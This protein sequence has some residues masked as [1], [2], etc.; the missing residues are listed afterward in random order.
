MA[1]KLSKANGAGHD[2]PKPKKERKKREPV[3]MPAVTEEQKR[4]AMDRLYSAAKARKE[5][6]AAFDSAHGTYRK[7]FDEA[8]KLTG[9]TKKTMSWHMENRD[10][11]PHEIDAEMRDIA[12]IAQWTNMA[13]GFQASFSFGDAPT[14]QPSDDIAAAREQGRLAGDSDRPQENPYP[15]DDP[16][17]AAWQGAYL[18]RQA[19]H[20]GAS[21][22]SAEAHA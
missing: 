22:G 3:A 8:C 1:R 14:N 11:E 12:R 13:S 2:A 18:G 15:E 21:N 19:E 16:R 17:N 9:H 5:K 20:M 6:K 4:E 7:A 10:R